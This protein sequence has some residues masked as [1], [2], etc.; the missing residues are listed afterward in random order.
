M[1]SAYATVPVC[2]LTKKE[3]SPPPY[4]GDDEE[5]DR[6]LPLPRD[7]G[8]PLHRALLLYAVYRHGLVGIL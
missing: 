2:D 3:N 6:L 1:K 4:V 8:F 5:L 7:V